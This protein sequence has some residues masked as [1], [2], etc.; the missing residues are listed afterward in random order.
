MKM[1][2]LGLHHKKEGTDPP[3][4]TILIEKGLCLYIL[5]NG[6]GEGPSASRTGKETAHLF[7]HHVKEQKKVLIAFNEDPSN[8][9]R[10][11]VK[12][13]LQSII[14]K[15][16]EKVFSQN[17]KHLPKKAIGTTLL[18]GLFIGTDVFLGNLGNGTV[19]LSLSLIHI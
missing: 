7:V 12:Q 18:F 5:C 1:K 13:T 8:K 10:D 16:N 15:M 17:Q 6:V 14:Q 4:D 9:K 11:L 19:Y 2:A 3:K